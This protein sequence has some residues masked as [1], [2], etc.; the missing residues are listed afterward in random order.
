MLSFVEWCGS[1]MLSFSHS[2]YMKPLININPNKNHENPSSY[3]TKYKKRQQK[4]KS[5]AKFLYITYKI[6]AFLFYL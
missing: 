1:N 3:S 6:V 2:G 4:N 5:H